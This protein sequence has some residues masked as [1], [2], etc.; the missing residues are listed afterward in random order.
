MFHKVIVHS[1]QFIFGDMK[2]FYL[3]HFKKEKNSIIFSL[4]DAGN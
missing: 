2:I 4:D 3:C 1:I